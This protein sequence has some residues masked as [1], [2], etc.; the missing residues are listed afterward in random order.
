MEIGHLE[1]VS[2]IREDLAFFKGIH[3]AGSSYDGLGIAACLRSGA[4]AA[5]E[6]LIDLEIEKDQSISS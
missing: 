6:C 1:L 4:K 3:L 5:T 2:K